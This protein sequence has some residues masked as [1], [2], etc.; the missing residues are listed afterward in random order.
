MEVC[1]YSSKEKIFTGCQACILSLLF[2][3]RGNSSRLIDF[4]FSLTLSNSIRRV[5]FMVSGNYPFSQ[6]ATFRIN[7]GRFQIINLTTNRNYRA[8]STGAI[9]SYRLLTKGHSR[10][11]MRSWLIRQGNR[12]KVNFN[13]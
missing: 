10:V 8:T 3:Q 5:N 7:S 9:K 13:M 4:S 11:F 2:N 12:H 1:V 6:F